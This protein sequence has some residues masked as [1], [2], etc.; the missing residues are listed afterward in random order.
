MSRNLLLFILIIYSWA[1]NAQMPV[2]SWN[3]Y[4][5][6][7]KAFKVSEIGNKI[8]CATD[9]ALFSLD[10]K[11]GTMDRIN[12]VNSLSDLQISAFNYN[13]ANGI[14][15]VGYANS[16]LDIIDHNKV[17]NIPDIKMKTIIGSKSINA[18][19]FQGDNAYLSTAFGIV[20]VNLKKKEIKDTYYIGTDGGNIEVYGTACDDS[21]LYAVTEKGIF[22]GN[23]NSAE[24][25]DFNF[26]QQITDVPNYNGKFNAITFFKGRIYLN[27]SSGDQ[28]GDRLYRQ[29]SSGGWESFNP[30]MQTNN[31][32]LEN[33]YGYLVVTS[34]DQV[35]VLDENA[36]EVR[37]ITTT[38]PADA[39]LDKDNIL[40]I[41][42]GKRGL[43]NAENSGVNYT[44][45][46]PDGPASNQSYY[47]ANSGKGLV[48]VGGGRT[49]I[50]G[51]NYQPLEV[52]FFQNG[53]W[54]NKKNDSIIDPIRIAIDPT[55]SSKTYIAC[56]GF[57]VLE[58]ENDSLMH[59]YNQKNTNGAL[60]NIFN[61]DS[62]YVR[63]G[64][65]NFDAQGNLWVTNVQ[66]P[67][68]LSVRKADGTWKAFRYGNYANIAWVGDILIT[69][70]NQKWIDV[71]SLRTAAS[72]ILVLNDNNTPEN[73]DDDYLVNLQVRYNENAAFTYAQSVNCLVEDKNQNVWIGTDKG[74][75]VC[76]SPSSVLDDGII[77]SNRILIPRNDGTNNADALL[78]TE[79]ILSMSIDG[80]NRK[81]IATE[82][83]GVYLISDDG[84]KQLLH[85]TA[86]NSP[87]F[88]NFVYCITID[89]KS[90]EVFFATDKGLLSYRGTAAEGGT[91]FADLLVFPNPV[92]DTYQGVITVSGLA[93]DVNVKFTDI[94]GNLVYETK[95][96]GG[97]AVWD[98]R[99]SS[100]QRVSTGV[101]LIFC[102]N[103]DGSKT[104]VGKLLFIH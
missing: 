16:N 32:A 29:S 38:S 93:S 14:M 52:S 95:A 23:L 51:N 98:G 40:W 4:L 71:L 84:M 82:K 77:N 70:S 99:N 13:P 101:Y 3:D 68:V 7:T 89:P 42:D 44:E 58:Y 37:S 76:Y 12:K 15:V 41:A 18:I 63:I 65:V 72:T 47:L 62:H 85:F 81:W 9:G 5:S 10:K 2:G 67:N 73:L 100:G 87:L 1:L 78:A 79:N 45:V 25:V 56:W 55:N 69:S 27:Y 64:G 91:D 94:S 50:L 21:L 31:L 102:T 49:A 8:Y 26:W 74:I 88:S 24:L 36:N 57:G 60:Q 96:L 34:K 11:E 104:Q 20:V 33:A 103:E 43:L 97:Q 17:I 46:H 90:G 35:E 59:I 28:G 30:S 6:Y 80:A 86:E 66:V 19:S 92:R 48:M 39:I 83:S 75:A 22:K 54:N 53:T 61:D